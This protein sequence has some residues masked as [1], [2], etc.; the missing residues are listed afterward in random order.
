MEKEKEAAR[1]R[2]I[3]DFRYYEEEYEKEVARRLFIILTVI[4]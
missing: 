1:R 2:I 3:S 4:C